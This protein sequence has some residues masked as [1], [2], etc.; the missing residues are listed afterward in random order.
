MTTMETRFVRDQL[1]ASLR[2]SFPTPLTTTEVSAWMPWDKRPKAYRIL[3][4]L[5]QRGIIRRCYVPG[6]KQTHWSYLPDEE[7]QSSIEAM[8]SLFK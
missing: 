6:Q 3:R 8:E 4:A 2:D 5:E 7:L 1:V